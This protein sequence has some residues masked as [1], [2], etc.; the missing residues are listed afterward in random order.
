MSVLLYVSPEIVI[1]CRQEC[2][3]VKQG[4]TEIRKRP[5]RTILA[6]LYNLQ[7]YL[8]EFEF[9]IGRFVSACSDKTARTLTYSLFIQCL[10]T[11]GSNKFLMR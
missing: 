10:L 9:I 8:H 1:T 11:S 5:Y 6:C 4:N 2:V 3:R 7:R